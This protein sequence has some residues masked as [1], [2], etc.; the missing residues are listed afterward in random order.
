[1]M[2]NFE[3]K[4][5]QGVGLFFAVAAC[6][7]L[8]LGCGG[9]QRESE[10]REQSNLKPLALLYG[11]YIGQNRGQPPAS[12]EQFKQFVRA[13]SSE[14]LASLGVTDVE[15]IF[16]SSRDQKPYVVLYGQAALSGPPGPAG[17]PVIAYELEGAG[18][19]R[20]VAS[21]MGAVEE[22]DEARFKELVPGAP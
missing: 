9:S 22:V 1:M 6:C 11:Q 18:G 21:N 10:A 12:E 16:V 8:P 3:L 7:I 4:T 15:Q 19:T 2:K 5:I 17:A 20:F 13:L 14:R